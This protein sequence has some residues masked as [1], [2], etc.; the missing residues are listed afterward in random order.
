MKK[1][2]TIA[3]LL[4]LTFSYSQD[5]YQ[6][7]T[8]AVKEIKEVSITKKAFKKE[9]DRFVYDVSRSPVAKGNTAFGILKA[10]PLV[11]ST[12]D[13]TL[14]VLG[15]SNA[16]IFMNGRRT[17]M[18]AEAVVELLKNTPAENISKIEVITVPGSE[19]NV[20]SSEAVI[21]IVLKKKLDDG[22]NGNFRLTNH[23]DYYNQQSGAVSL[24]FRK[25]KLG[26]STNI[27]G[28]NWQRRQYY[29]LQNGTVEYQNTSEG[30]IADPNLNLGGY[31]NMDYALTDRQN[32]ALSWNSWA[33]RSYGSKGE[34]FNT[35]ITPAGTTFTKTINDEDARSYNNSLNLN[36]EIK[37]DSSGSKLNMNVAYLNYKRF[38]HNINST[39]N[40]NTQRETLD[41]TNR[42]KQRAPQVIDNYAVTAD[43][44]HKFKND[45]TVSVG[46]N[47]SKTET[48]N[49]TYFEKL[50]QASGIYIK[51]DNQSNHFIYQEQIS[52]AYASAEKKIGGKFSGKLGLRLE[53]THSFGEILNSDLSIK[54]DYS[55]LLPFASISYDINE[56]N[57]I[58]YSFS[59]RIRRPSF[60]EL[61]PVRTY[62]TPT[63]YIQNNPFVKASEVYNNNFTYMFK[64][65]YFFIVS[66]SLT[67]DDFSQIPLQ[68]GDELRYIRTNYG[69]K[70]E[71]SATVG[72]QKS[73]F[74]SILTTNTNLGLQINR[75]DAFLAQDPITGDQFSPFIIDTHTNSLLIQ[76]YNTLRLSSKKDW[77]LGVNYWYVGAQIL[78][79][80]TLQP[81]SSLDISIKKIWNDWTFNL[82]ATDLLR[83]N[84]V[85]VDDTQGNGNYNFVT[86][87]QFNR[88]VQ[89]SVTYSF[90]NKK[91]KGVRQIDDAS[92]DAKS[93][94]R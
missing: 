77:F 56:Q 34:L 35:I 88:G 86:N 72:T 61:N 63:N 47:L 18:N 45:L 12:D 66:H 41:L 78:N 62:L 71:F 14:K 87:D 30:P 83:T 91:I 8:S 27:N 42:F 48:D 16:V 69:D 59:S 36:Y 20:E 11:S 43:Y 38:Q 37:T 73:F 2:L 22:L 75:V 17:N 7:D 80:G 1:Q 26:I 15:K 33:N 93:R 10:T 24:N 54:R 92:K 9:S 19:F 21:N 55:N 40:S 68:N 70:V 51:D 32:I 76:T 44:L 39:F 29:S 53:N 74:N 5:T 13:K 52:G 28:S 57:N 89:L 84:I 6:Q 4:S 90:G 3:A 67:K 85:K 49:D 94:T 65:S 60:W 31:L 46:G 81:L 58:S 23:Q 50:N 64:Q 79:I 25:N 82:E